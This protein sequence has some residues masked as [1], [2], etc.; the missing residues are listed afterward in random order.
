MAENIHVN[1]RVFLEAKVNNTQ[2]RINTLIITRSLVRRHMRPV[3]PAV[4]DPVQVA[5]NAAEQAILN[6]QDFD[7]TVDIDAMNLDLPIHQA[8]LAAVIALENAN[9]LTMQVP[10]EVPAHLAAVDQPNMR[11]ILPLCKPFGGVTM[12]YRVSFGKLF[13][14]AIRHNMTHAMIG[15]AICAI[16]DGEANIDYQMKAHLPLQQI[17]DYFL[18]V[19]GTVDSPQ[20]ACH[21]MTRFVRKADESIKACMA[22]YKSPLERAMLVH[23][24]LPPDANGVVPRQ[25]FDPQML[26]CLF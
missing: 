16:L 23:E 1:K 21:E 7:M 19:N 25:N 2:D 22:R 17:V 11:E 24:P 15:E 3:D 26:E 9:K 10:P 13:N 6:A 4:V 8:Q 5:A 14:Y 18:T 20:S 12:N